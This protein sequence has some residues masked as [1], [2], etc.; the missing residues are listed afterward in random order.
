M[1]NYNSP[2]AP[3]A[4]EARSSRYWRPLV[5]NGRPVDLSHL[6]PFVLACAVK[7]LGRI[8]KVDVRF[9]NHCFTD[10]FDPAKHEP[11]WKIMDGK[12]ERVFCPRR[13]HMSKRLPELIRTLPDAAVHRTRADRTFVFV[14]T[15]EDESGQAYTMFFHLRKQ[16]GDG[17][18][19]ALV[20]ES[21]YEHPDLKALLA[22]TTKVR[23]PVLCALVFENKPLRS[24]ARR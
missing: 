24:Q 7:N 17:C 20:V 19:L 5:I 15:L 21:A 18:D 1:R 13:H 14:A 9:T 10:H 16:R 2:A 11:S 4:L 22:R 12:R 8:L 6:E 23:F 3:S